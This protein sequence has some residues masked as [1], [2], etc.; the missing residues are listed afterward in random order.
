MFKHVST[1]LYNMFWNILPN[2]IAALLQPRK[3]SCAQNWH[4][5]SESPLVN[6]HRKQPL[7]IV[8][9]PHLYKQ[10]GSHVKKTDIS[11]PQ[12]ADALIYLAL[13]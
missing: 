4:Y 2:N 6:T 3:L 11:E 10:A 13:I 5:T 9:C 7:L 8:G 12:G 1:Y